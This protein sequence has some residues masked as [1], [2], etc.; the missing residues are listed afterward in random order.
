MTQTPHEPTPSPGDALPRTDLATLVLRVGV[1]AVFIHHA[2]HKVLDPGNA[3]GANWVA[4]LVNTP[5]GAVDHSTY[6]SAVQLCIAWGELLSGVA[7]LVGLLTRVAVL[8]MILIQAGAVYFTVY[9][10][11]FSL[12]KEGG[13]EFN[14]IILAV[15]AGVLLLG[16]G[17]FSVDHLIARRWE[18]VP[19]PVPAARVEG[20]AALSA[21]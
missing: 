7:L 20:S 8:G 5:P 15:C 19:A 18:K 11:A 13:P 16:A 6:F 4:N 12:T 17:R 14:V 21:P 2:L 9:S 1:A 3:W 10:A